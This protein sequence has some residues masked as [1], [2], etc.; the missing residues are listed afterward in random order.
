MPPRSRR[1]SSINAGQTS[2]SV[3]GSQRGWRSL[4]ISS[5]RMPSG[6]SACAQQ[7]SAARY[8]RRS[9]SAS[10]RPFACFHN[11]KLSAADVGEPF[12]NAVPAACSHGSSLCSERRR[13]A[14]GPRSSP[15]MSVSMAAAW[16]ITSEGGRTAPSPAA[17]STAVSVARSAGASPVHGAVASA[18]HT[19]PLRSW[20]TS[21]SAMPQC[22][23]SAAFSGAAV[24]ARNNPVRPGMR[25]RNQL[26]PTSGNRPMPISGIARRV[27]SVTTRCDA[28]TI[29]PTPPPITM[30]WPHTRNGFGKVWIRWSSSYS[31]LKKASATGLK[32]PPCSRIERYS[33][34]RSPPA[35]KA[36]FPAASRA[37]PTTVGSAAQARSCGVSSR[38][39]SADSA[40]SAAGVLRV[41]TPKRR[42]LAAWT[43]SNR[44]TGVSVMDWNVS[45]GRRH[46][47]GACAR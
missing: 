45:G 46:P 37:T 8:S 19:A 33:C 40:F 24:S 5:A 43:W 12:A 36:L 26:P 9:T 31:S 10:G 20:G 18:D 17:R 16:R 35:Q 6:K 32:A 41:A 27:A 29:R 44:T 21:T 25:G 39:M 3:G 22:R 1:W 30:P 42:P 4:S 47:R 14:I 15:A 11:A 28:P 38:T 2:A 23:A 7:P 34:R 13:S